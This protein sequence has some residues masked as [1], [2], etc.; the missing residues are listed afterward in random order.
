M[1]CP[2]SC[3]VGKV[4][5][6]VVSDNTCSKLAVPSYVV[7]KYL[8][9]FVEFFSRDIKSCSHDHSYARKI[10]FQQWFMLPPSLKKYLDDVFAYGEFFAFNDGPYGSGGLMGGKKFVLSTTWNAP[11]DV[12]HDPAKFFEGR[13][14]EDV[15]LPMR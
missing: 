13:S 14:P 7:D 10:R 4:W 8:F 5:Y 9:F 3:G 11:S 6:R 12:F 2:K 1:I 15:L